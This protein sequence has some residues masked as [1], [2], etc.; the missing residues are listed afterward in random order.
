MN[1]KIILAKQSIFTEKNWK[2]TNKKALLH[3]VVLFIYL[4]IYFFAV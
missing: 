3:Q 4:T 1:K 2:Q